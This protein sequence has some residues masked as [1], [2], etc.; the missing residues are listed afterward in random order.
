MR[1]RFFAISQVLFFITRA[2]VKTEVAQDRMCDILRV[3]FNT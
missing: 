2:K 3:R 1:V